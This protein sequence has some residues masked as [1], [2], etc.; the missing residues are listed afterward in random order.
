M[1]RG[2]HLKIILIF[3]LWENMT[4]IPKSIAS[5]TV[6]FYKLQYKIM[7]VIGIA[8]ISIF[9]LTALSMSTNSSIIFFIFIIGIIAFHMMTFKYMK[10]N[11]LILAEEV[12]EVENGLF[13]RNGKISETIEYSNIQS[14]TY[15]YSFF[16][17]KNNVVE[18]NFINPTILGDKVRF[19]SWADASNYQREFNPFPVK[20]PETRAW[21]N[22]L[23]EKISQSTK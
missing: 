22:A 10:E 11:I 7:Y 1:V 15:R 18:L 3:E 19:I 13:I 9:A 21:V 4:L 20:T 17:I 12:K 2:T 8:F 23:Q 16:S 5:D 6:Y 14:V